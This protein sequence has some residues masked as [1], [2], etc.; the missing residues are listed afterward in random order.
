MCLGSRGEAV[1]AERES[2][3]QV[4][5]E[6][7]ELISQR[8]RPALENLPPDPVYAYRVPRGSGL[9]GSHDGIVIGNLTASFMHL[10]DTASNHWVAR[11]VE[12]VRARKRAPAGQARPGSPGAWIGY[13]F[14]I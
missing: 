8:Q 6:E 11:F 3:H 9:D 14:G 5:T 4:E 2:A 13:Q 1:S 7:S 10:R 12:F